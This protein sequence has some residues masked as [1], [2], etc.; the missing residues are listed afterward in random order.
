[1][2]R[3]GNPISVKRVIDIA[4]RFF[5]L[6]C[7]FTL[8]YSLSLVL[9]LDLTIYFIK[10]KSMLLGRT[11]RHILT[12]LG[13]PFLGILVGFFIY[14]YGWELKMMD[15][16]GAAASSGGS[17]SI[18]VG[19]RSEMG[20]SSRGS[21]WTSFDINV[22]GEPFPNEEGEEVAQPDAQN[23]PA[24]PVASP[25]GAQEQAPLPQAPAPAQEAHPAEVSELKAEIKAL[26]S[27][28]VR[29]ESEKGVGPLTILFPEQREINSSV[30]LL[31]MD[32][33]EI[34]SEIDVENLREWINRIKEDKSLL[35]GL[36]REYLP[37]KK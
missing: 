37:P 14:G 6:C 11:I 34:T 26:I 2:A 25:G 35:K 29:E 17:N 13:L 20:G 15:P 21:G 23:A 31:I 4:I 19:G 8:F 22:L 7:V 33:L 27:D 9:D 16:E 3:K 5:I 24:N 28:Q 1:M 18:S 30:A 36:I 32:Q 12:M 10:L